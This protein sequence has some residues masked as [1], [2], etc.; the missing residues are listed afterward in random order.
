MHRQGEKESHDTENTEEAYSGSSLPNKGAGALT[1][2]ELATD[3]VSRAIFHHWLPDPGKPGLQVC[4][5]FLEHACLFP[6][7]WVL[8]V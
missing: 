8:Y 1:G 6:V 2:V 4:M 3:F 7:P 5:P